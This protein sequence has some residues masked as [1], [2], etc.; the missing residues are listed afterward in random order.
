[1]PVVCAPVIKFTVPNDQ[2]PLD[3]GKRRRVPRARS[4]IR[5]AA[6]AA[7]KP[8]RYTAPH[9]RKPKSDRRDVAGTAF[10]I[11]THDERRKRNLDESGSGDIQAPILRPK[12]NVT[13]CYKVLILAFSSWQSSTFVLTASVDI[14]NRF[15]YYPRTMSTIRKFVMREDGSPSTICRAKLQFPVNSATLSVTLLSQRLLTG[16][17][18]K[19][20]RIDERGWGNELSKRRKKKKSS[21]PPESYGRARV[22]QHSETSPSSLVGRAESQSLQFCHVRVIS[23]SV[24]YFCV[25][26]E[27]YQHIQETRDNHKKCCIHVHSTETYKIFAHN[28]I[29][30]SIKNRGVPCIYRVDLSHRGLL[31]ASTEIYKVGT[32][33][34]TTTTPTLAAAAANYV[35]RVY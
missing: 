11:C 35:F 4:L 1:M 15:K 10:V 2:I 24:W 28:H 33:T 21:I 22:Y 8:H 7:R 25:I 26:L 34:T 3:F 12:G 14:K 32:T 29:G 17:R 5:P 19:G 30:S 16:R 20:E 27:Y 6:H 23:P 13:R 31:G 9:P 18:G